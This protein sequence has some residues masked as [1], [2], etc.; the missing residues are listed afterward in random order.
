MLK[1]DFLITIIGNFS[2]VFSLENVGMFTRRQ[3][4]LPL[5]KS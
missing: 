4:K 5:A 1:A 2:C 3:L